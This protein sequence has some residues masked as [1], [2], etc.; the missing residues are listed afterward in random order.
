MFASI[1]FT[2]VADGTHGG[3][4]LTGVCFCG[5]VHPHNFAETD[6]ASITKLDVEMFYHEFWKPIYFGVKRSKIKV[7]WHKSSASVGF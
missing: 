4:V 1:L 2:P 6:A 7:T 3:W 5:F